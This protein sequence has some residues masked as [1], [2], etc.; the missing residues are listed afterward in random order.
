MSEDVTRR[1]WHHHHQ[2]LNINML[3]STWHFVNSSVICVTLKLALWPNCCLVQFLKGSFQSDLVERN[4]IVGTIDIFC[5]LSVYYLNILQELAV[6]F[7]VRFIWVALA[8]RQ[9]QS[10]SYSWKQNDI[11]INILCYYF[12]F[13]CCK[14][15][16]IKLIFRR[17]LDN[18]STFKILLSS[19]LGAS[20]FLSW[21]GDR[22]K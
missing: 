8:N 7:S 19:Q 13:R 1:G 18:I 10:E 17:E 16:T 20:F 4:Y 12:Y 5:K 6:R 2:S 14:I 15:G 3:E 9:Y 21:P 11:L 22:K